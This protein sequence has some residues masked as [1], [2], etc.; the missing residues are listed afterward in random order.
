[1]LN[2]YI[3]WGDDSSLY[4]FRRQGAGWKIALVDEVNWYDSPDESQSW[5]RYRI[6]PR[7]RDGSWLVVTGSVNNHLVSAWQ[8][9]T[10]TA[11][12]PSDDP[13]RPRLLVRNRQFAYVHN[14]EDHRFAYRFKVTAESFS[15]SF[16]H[17]IEYEAIWARHGYRVIHG[18]AYEEPPVC[19]LGRLNR[20]VIVCPE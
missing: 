20:K 5:F 17:D 6:S 16:V 12:A 8:D 11:Q 9:V 19:Y 2:I 18:R 1:V 14:A 7:G 3:A 4:I 10:Y 13:L 15:V